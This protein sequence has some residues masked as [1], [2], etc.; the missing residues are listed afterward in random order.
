MRG[1][2]IFLLFILLSP[3]ILEGQ[4]EADR[5]EVDKPP[6][7]ATRAA[8]PARLT[9][10]LGTLDGPAKQWLTY[11]FGSVS[12]DGVR[13]RPVQIW[14]KKS[15]VKQ[16]VTLRLV[17]YAQLEPGEDK[18]VMLRWEFLDG[19]EV[20]VDF[21]A[22]HKIGASEGE[23]EWEE[24]SLRMTEEQFNRV[25]TGRGKLRLTVEVRPES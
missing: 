7:D 25:L 19:D 8:S 2:A 18:D 14:K 5:V 4:G 1:P 24:W 3:A 12:V 21:K 13:L 16:F 23:V 15:N 11:K 10:D 6:E 20:V 9:V 22:P 17:A